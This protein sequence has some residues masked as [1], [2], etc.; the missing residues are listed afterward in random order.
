MSCSG[1]L[2]HDQH[3]LM[4]RLFYM[5]TVC[6]NSWPEACDLLEADSG[7][8]CGLALLGAFRVGSVGRRTTLSTLLKYIST[9]RA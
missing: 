3:E 7:V 8:D 2:R 9:L 5:A 4:D 6:Q 1:G